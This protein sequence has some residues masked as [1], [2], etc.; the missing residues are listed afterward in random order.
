MMITF[1]VLGILILGI[2]LVAKSKGV[3]PLSW[4]WHSPV[5]QIKGIAINGYDPVLY[6]STQTA[7]KGQ[8]K[9]HWN[10]QGAEWRFA[11][12]E[13]QTAFQQNP[14]KYAP[15][16]GGYCAFAVSKGFTAKPD[17][18]AWQIEDGKLFLFADE[19]MKVKW[20][21]QLKEGIQTKGA[22]KWK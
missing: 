22:K 11:S 9:W 2:G 14:E 13:T 7:K 4:G 1:V 20:M 17:P 21:A 15:E 16:F 12:K 10:W 6:F 5:S 8:K 18:T 19:G 3:V